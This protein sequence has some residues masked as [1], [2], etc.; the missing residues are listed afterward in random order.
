MKFGIHVPLDC[1]FCGKIVETFDHL[2]FE[3]RLCHWMGFQRAILDW[4]SE[5]E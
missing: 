3:Y 2:Y 4:D 5:V 1:A